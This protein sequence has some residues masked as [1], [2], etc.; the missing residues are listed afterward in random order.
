MQHEDPH[1]N[2]APENLPAPGRI[3]IANPFL[4]DPHFLRSV[5]LLCEHREE[6]SFGF[7]VNK[8]FNRTLDELFPDQVMARIPVYFGGPVQ[9]DTLHFLHLEPE[10]IEGGRRVLPGVYW[11]GD[12]ERVLELLN[13]GMA[14]ASRIKFFV[15]Y[16]GWGSGQLDAELKEDSWIVSRGSR[17]LIFGE[18]VHNVWSQSLHDMGDEFAQMA[19][20]PIDPSLN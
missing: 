11:G 7:I 13:T 17:D 14:D 1:I 3:L 19:N 12:F 20:Y 2:P 6:G 10:L 18:R 5:I 9:V 16:A 4:K 8:L 15:G